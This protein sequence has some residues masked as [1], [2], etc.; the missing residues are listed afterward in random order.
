MPLQEI[1]ESAGH[2]VS[3][4]PPLA[5]GPQELSPGDRVD[6]VVIAERRGA[7]FATEL[8]RWRA[9][10]PPPGILAVIGTPAGKA[11]AQ[12]ARVVAVNANTRPAEIA[13]SVDRAL[14]IRWAGKL[15]PAYARG[16]L[17]LPL[18]PEPGVD[19]GRIVAAARK[20]D[21]ELVREALRW[22][23]AHYVT[24]TDQVGPLREQRALDVPELETLR[25]IDGS[26]TLQTTIRLV[27]SGGGTL[28]PAGAGRALWAL[29]CIGAIELTREPID[30]ST[31]ERRA[32]TAARV[33]LRA[34][35]TR[36]ARGTHYDLLEIHPTAEPS[37][38]DHACRMLGVRFAPERLATLDLGDCAPLVPT[39]WDTILRARAQL[40]DPAERLKYNEQ[41]RKHRA[42]IESPWAFG[43]NDQAR[44]E[45]AFARGQR[46]LLS[47]AAFKAV[48]EMAGAARA[49]ADHPDYEASLAWAR[50]R[51]EAEKGGRADAVKEERAAAEAALAGR[52]PWP[53]ALV[54]LALLCAADADPEAARWHL[55]EALACDPN[56]P[57]AKQ[58]LS[59]LGPAAAKP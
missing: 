31:P 11:A 10:E 39:T 37:E 35:Q 24:A 29:A 19:F 46:A 58:L 44:A 22:Y 18:P 38:I 59:R 53:R 49:H 55:R 45:E 17:G 40:S 4:K 3:W 2:Q 42:Q 36:M 16:A 30:L 51:A 48:S 41:V 13:R 5:N 54:A 8:E 34:R 21:L 23:A 20:A 15:A 7:S 33:H 14:Q 12:E 47:G 56:H 26:H 32:V 1:L 28:D 43:P 6:V 57:V 9:H 27:G 25:R 50:Y 52:R